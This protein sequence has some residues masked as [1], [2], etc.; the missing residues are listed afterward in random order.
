M[1]PDRGIPYM[2]TD[3]MVEGK[4]RP[5]PGRGA[6]LGR[7]RTSQAQPPLLGLVPEVGV[8]TR[9]PPRHPVS[10]TTPSFGSRGSDP[11]F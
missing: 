10:L 5:L 1:D 8:L 9:R 2:P 4:E 7:A 11:W 3:W 6:P